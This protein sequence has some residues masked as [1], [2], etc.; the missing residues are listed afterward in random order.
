L[1]GHAR[2]DLVDLRLCE[3]GQRQRIEALRFV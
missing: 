2:D 1:T 3:Q